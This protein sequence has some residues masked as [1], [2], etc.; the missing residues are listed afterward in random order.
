LFL[1]ILTLWGQ[2][3]C[4]DFGHVASANTG[5]LRPAGV[6]LIFCKAELKPATT[7]GLRPA[8]V[9][10]VLKQVISYQLSA[11]NQNLRTGGSRPARRLTFFNAK[12]VSKKA[13]S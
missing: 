9:L 8:V 6:A 3:K 2:E 5:G 4:A 7:A 11:E 13:V 10:F 12:K 1:T